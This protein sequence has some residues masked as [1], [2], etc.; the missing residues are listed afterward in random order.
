MFYGFLL[1]SFARFSIEN[2]NNVHEKSTYCNYRA[3][4]FYVCCLS[5]ASI[6][7]KLNGLISLQIG[8]RGGRVG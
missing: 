7:H 4:K 6:L 8:G 5:V 1:D 2:K 3:I